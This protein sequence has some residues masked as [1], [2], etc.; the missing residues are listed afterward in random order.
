MIIRGH[1]HANILPAMFED[2]G[3]GEI[4]IYVRTICGK[5]LRPKA[6][7]VV[8]IFDFVSGDDSEL[9]LWV[10]LGGGLTFGIN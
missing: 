2:L 5:I 1:K 10:S 8:K 4:Y 6:E 7:E 3:E 9:A